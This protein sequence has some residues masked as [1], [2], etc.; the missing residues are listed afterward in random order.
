MERKE[1]NGLKSF[2]CFKKT[3]FIQNFIN[4]IFSFKGGTPI[5][6]ALQF[7]IAFSNKRHICFKIRASIGDNLFIVDE[8]FPANIWWGQ[9]KL[10]RPKSGEYH[11]V[12]SN[13]KRNRF[14]DFNFDITFNN[15]KVKTFE[16]T[17]GSIQLAFI[18]ISSQNSLCS[19]CGYHWCFWSL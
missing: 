14:F 12:G 19:W 5:L 16:N 8:C 15:W 17:D 3:K 13:L 11:G 10:D 2:Y 1:N 7:F 4:Y 18:A 6:A 9:E